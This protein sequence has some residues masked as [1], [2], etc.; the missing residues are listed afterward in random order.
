PPGAP[1]V[2]GRGGPPAPANAPAAAPPAAAPGCGPAPFPP[3]PTHTRSP[4][5]GPIDPG[6]IEPC[7]ID[8]GPIEPGPIE[9]GPIEPGPIADP[10]APAPPA[11]GP[12]CWEGR[13]EI[14]SAAPM[15]IAV[16]GSASTATGRR[17]SSDTSCE[18]SGIR[19][20]PPTSRTALRSSGVS[21][22][23]LIARRSD[24]IVSSSA[25]R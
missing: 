3:R 22:A 5:P 4:Q 24:R 17:S 8:P 2:D 1:C 15:A 12:R 7:P 6:P 16:V 9:P 18:T 23:E 11:G 21:P 19:D 10:A 13:G 14:G 20:D 25:G